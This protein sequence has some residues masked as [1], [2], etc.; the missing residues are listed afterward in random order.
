MT[1]IN[2]GMPGDWR[3]AAACTQTD[4]DL[5]F[6]EHWQEVERAK[7]FCADKCPARARNACLKEALDDNIQFGVW[8]GLNVRER[9]AL[10]RKTA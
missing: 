8:G 9:N 7:K 10:K 2:L 1:A 4:P 5:F 6:Q 3:L